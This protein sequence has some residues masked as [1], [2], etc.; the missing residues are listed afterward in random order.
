MDGAACSTLSSPQ[1]RDDETC[2]RDTAISMKDLA[3]TPSLDWRG[4]LS[5][6]LLIGSS[7]RMAGTTPH[8]PC[9]INLRA[10]GHMSV[11]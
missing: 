2:M 1:H 5:S 9:S 10:A 7:A 3:M 6:Q 8:T 11:C 4:R